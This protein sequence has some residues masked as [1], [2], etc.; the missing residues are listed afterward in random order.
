MPALNR[1]MIFQLALL[2]LIV[3]AQYIL[4]QWKPISTTERNLEVKGL[5][6]KL[7]LWKEK[8][9][10][11]EWWRRR[12]QNAWNTLS[13]FMDHFEKY[14]EKILHGGPVTD[15]DID[16]DLEGESP[17]IEVLKF[18]QSNGYYGS[19]T[20]P[21]SPR[22][23]HV[24]F[25]V[26]QVVRNKMMGYRGV[27][28]GWDLTVK[29]PEQ[30]IKE[31]I[32]PE[33]KHTLSHPFYAILIDLR[34]VHIPIFLVSYV[35]EADLELMHVSTLR[36]LSQPNYMILVNGQDRQSFTTAYVVQEAL[37]SVENVKVEHSQIDEYFE[38]FDGSRYLAR[39][40]LKKIYPHDQ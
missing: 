29:A 39:P 17:A 2:L 15:D 16:D 35:S 18:R 6:D 27:I 3:P 38:A 10:N 36:Y 11:P 22:P 12:G 9:F 34:D 30:W 7:H 8:F 19:S 13:N 26:G 40:W 1:G 28:I 24:K 20:E 21:R 31:H 14:G 32:P 5:I 25:R 37:E 4:T 33:N 23:R